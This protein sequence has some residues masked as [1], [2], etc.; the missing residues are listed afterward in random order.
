MLRLLKT[1]CLLLFAL[2][3]VQ[4][5]DWT[6]EKQE[7]GITIETRE[8]EGQGLK[9]FRGKM[10]VEASLSSLLALLDDTE[11]APQWMHD[12]KSLSEV[13]AK[14]P[15]DR[16]LYLVNSAPWPLRPRDAY[17]HAQ[18]SQ[19]PDSKAVTVA[20]S[21]DPDRGLRAKRMVRI[22]VM[23]G[24]WHFQPSGDKRVDVSYTMFVNPG[25]RIPKALANMVVVDNPFGTLSGMRRMLAS[26]DYDDAEIDWVVEP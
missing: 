26:G 3:V 25:G 23:Y 2:P 5:A 24:S 21:A 9:E 11:R 1:L 4:A 15:R 20:L 7:N 19:D 22:P 18:S 10:I 13:T 8:V 6:I 12:N 14:S 16:W 17:V